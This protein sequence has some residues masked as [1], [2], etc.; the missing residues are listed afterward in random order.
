MNAPGSPAGSALP[1]AD[2][3]DN[4]ATLAGHGGEVASVTQE[5]DGEGVMP[6]T[7][8]NFATSPLSRQPRA[9]PLPWFVR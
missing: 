8:G 6:V 9:S 4:F 1:P 5:V 7:G 3:Y 2:S